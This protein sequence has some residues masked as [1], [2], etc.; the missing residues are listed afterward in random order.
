MVPSY[1]TD[2]IVMCR[3]VRVMT[4]TRG[5]EDNLGDSGLYIHHVASMDQTQG[6]ELGAKHLY[7]LSPLDGPL[8]DHWVRRFPLEYSFLPG[9]D[10]YKR[11]PP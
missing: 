10:S 1:C 11:C 9:L 4:P 6:A 5:S 3:A 7:T 8:G 2:L